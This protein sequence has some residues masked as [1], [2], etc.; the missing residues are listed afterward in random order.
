MNEKKYIIIVDMRKNNGQV[1]FLT[2][3]D[4]DNVAK[5]SYGEA[6]ETVR[7][8]HL[9]QVFPYIILNMDNQEVV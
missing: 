2:H 4:S 6:I 5:F 8:H 3:G 7:I 1:M 9:C